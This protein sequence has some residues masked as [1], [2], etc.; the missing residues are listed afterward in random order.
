MRADSLA[1]NQDVI[2]L[3]ITCPEKQNV[4][5][6][7]PKVSYL[8]Q[9]KVELVFHEVESMQCSSVCLVGDG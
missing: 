8:L 9:L 1:I 3:L 5:C 6:R 7:L 4:V 2:I